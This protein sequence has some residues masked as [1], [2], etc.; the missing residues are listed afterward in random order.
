MNLFPIKFSEINGKFLVTNDAGDFFYCDEDSLLAL[1][2]G[3]PNE[4]FQ[5]FLTD[6][7]F[8]Y[9]TTD[10]YRFKTARYRTLRRRVIR[11]AITYVLLVP[12][13]RCN[14]SCSY[15]QVSRADEGAKGYDWTEEITTKSIQ[16]LDALQT[17]KLKIEFQGGEP[18][19]RPDLLSRVIEFA[20]GRF[21]ECEF[22]I[23]TNLQKMTPEF[24]GIIERPD[25]FIS[26][27]L[28]GPN[29]IHQRN[30]TESNPA[31]S[32]FF[33]NLEMIMK[34][35]GQEKV[36]AL[37]TITES[38]YPSLNRI[39]DEYK[40]RGFSGIYLR[41]VNFHGFARKQHASSRNLQANW[42][43]SYRRALDYIF[44]R[45]FEDDWQFKDFGFELLLKRIFRPSENGHV[46]LRSPNFVG[47]DYIVIDHDGALY[48]SDEARMLS[49]VG[50]V[51]LSIGHV[52]NG[53]NHSKIE[54]LNW[55]QIG[56]V[57]PD[58][59][60]CAFQP[61]C[62][63]DHF[64]D[65]SR[66]SRVDLP[67]NETAFCQSQMDGFTDVFERLAKNDPIEIF[68]I[69]GHLTDHFHTDPPFG[70]IQYA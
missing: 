1:V 28:D 54:E 26:T 18:S 24:E 48:P 43:A 50:L 11:K 55:N 29:D 21:S 33:V 3:R 47:Q 19:L 9:Q 67:K 53:M 35:Y 4:H 25:V 34:K 61:Y 36:S 17:D 14:L 51:D 6:K 23:C 15:C 38:D 8:G 39:V 68:N 56:E 20:S 46:D 2:D 59:I 44:K 57:N 66:Y 49:R 62:G 42:R 69:T 22:V 30:R 64:D 7:G 31:T 40:S 52:V 60:H 16:Y 41:P 5:Q 13:L 65:L 58:C 45:N 27:S 32:A 12:T 37:P 10:D 70:Q 63:I